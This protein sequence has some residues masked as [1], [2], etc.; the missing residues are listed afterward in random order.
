M[1]RL[2]LTLSFKR[3]RIYAAR[4]RNWNKSFRDMST[5]SFRYS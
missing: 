5:R 2:I 3:D 1:R 4:C